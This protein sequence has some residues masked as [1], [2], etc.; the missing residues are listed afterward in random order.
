MRTHGLVPPQLRR[1]QLPELWAT[2]DGVVSMLHGVP[3][4]IPI[5]DPGVDALYV[6]SC[7]NPNFHWATA[8]IIILTD[9]EDKWFRFTTGENGYGMRI[10]EINLQGCLRGVI[11]TAIGFYLEGKGNHAKSNGR[12]IIPEQK[13]RRKTLAGG[14]FSFPAIPIHDLS[15]ENDE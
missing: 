3:R 7:P 13:I 5:T 10:G 9:G 15:G 11:K 4:D 2:V 1:P 6:V 14:F 12:R 8:G